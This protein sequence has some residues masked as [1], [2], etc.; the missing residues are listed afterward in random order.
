MLEALVGALGSAD[1]GN[2][3]L[4]SAYRSELARRLAATTDGALPGVVFGVGGGEALDLAI[5]AVRG[6]TGRAEVI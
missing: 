6:C 1:V 4:A 5:K 3:H 2:H